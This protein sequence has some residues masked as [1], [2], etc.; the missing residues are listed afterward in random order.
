MGLF[1]WGKDKVTLVKKS[2]IKSKVKGILNDKL[3]LDGE[4]DE[5]V[6][7][8]ADKVIDK[9]GVENII[10]AKKIYDKLANKKT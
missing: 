9:L 5:R 8:V 10:N 4:Y 7:Q 6:D 1:D 2:V 3:E